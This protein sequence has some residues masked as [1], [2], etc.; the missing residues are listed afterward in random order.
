MNQI[1]ATTV[2]WQRISTSQGV[3]RALVLTSPGVPRRC[4]LVDDP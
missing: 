3:E 2:I 4:S 1:R